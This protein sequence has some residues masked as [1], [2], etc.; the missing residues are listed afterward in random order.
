MA[1]FDFL[2]S[3]D[4][5]LFDLDNTLYAEKDYLFAAYKAIGDRAAQLHAHIS[6]EEVS[7][8]LIHTFEQKG[9]AKLFDECIQQFQLNDLSVA[10]MLSIMRTVSIDPLLQLYPLSQEM[11]LQALHNSKVF[12]ITNGHVQQQENKVKHIDWCGLR[13]HIDIIYANSIEPKPSAASFLSLNI[14]A[15]LRCIYIG[16]SEVDQLFALQ[17]KIDFK[18][19][20]Q[21]NASPY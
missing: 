5:V 7:Q 11:L 10:D 1:R 19:V 15:H 6:T 14:P 9:R 16:D 17:C 4:V 12:I 2:R 3:Y 18:F 20:Q 13:K 8:F 21:L